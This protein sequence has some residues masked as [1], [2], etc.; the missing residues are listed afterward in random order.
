MRLPVSLSSIFIAS[1][2]MQSKKSTRVE[3]AVSTTGRVDE[4]W[5]GCGSVEEDEA[6][7]EALVAAGAFG[8]PDDGGR[9]GKLPN[10]QPKKSQNLRQI[11]NAVIKCSDYRINS[12]KNDSRRILFLFLCLRYRGRFHCGTKIPLATLVIVFSGLILLQHGCWF[13]CCSHSL[14]LRFW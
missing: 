8:S 1:R 11:M 12:P 2:M 7:A 5:I 14:S 6:E 9:F 4:W 13:G 10:S 3:V